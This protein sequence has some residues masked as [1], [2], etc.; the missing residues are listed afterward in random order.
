MSVRMLATWRKGW[1]CRRGVMR[2]GIRESAVCF[3]RT[4]AVPL[5]YCAWPPTRLGCWLLLSAI[6]GGKL[7]KLVQGR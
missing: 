7:A 5:T 4:S 2:V 3:E 6:V 1:A